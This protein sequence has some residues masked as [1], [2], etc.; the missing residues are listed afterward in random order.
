[1]SVKQPSQMSAKELLAYYQA[2]LD[3]EARQAKANG[4]LVCWSASVAPPELCVAMDIAMVYPETHA[5]GIGARKGALD[6]LE[7]ADRLG[8][9]VDCCSYG[10]VN[11]GYMELLK[12]EAMTGKTPE[13]L[14]NSPAARVPLPDLVITCNNICNTLLKWYENLAAELDIPC[15][16]IDVPFNHTMPVSEESKAYIADQFRNAISQLEV[17]CGRPFDYEKFHAVRQ[18]TQRSIAQWNRIATMSQYKP[19]PLNGF[20]LF[21]YMALV[22]C[23]RS[24]DYAEITFRKFADELEEKY[25]KGESAFKGAEKNRVAWEGIAVWP[26]LGHTFKTLKNQGSIMTGSAYPNIWDLT[27]DAEDETLHSMAEAYT[28]TYINT[29]LDNKV[30]VL[31]GIMDRGKCDGV[32]YHLN[33][34]CKLMS[35]LNVET[36]ELIQQ[37]NGLPYVSFDG[38][39]TDPRN[40]APAQ[41]DTRVE[42]LGEMMDQAAQTAGE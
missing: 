39:Q 27:Y 35:F 8:Y 26:Y 40:F 14:A 2:K 37:A 22:V 20:D 24:R 31:R 41:Y 29:C 10:R 30:K 18:Q 34:S 17:I 15:I 4:K 13:V 7:V 32:V 16:I 12:E 38:D 42:A 28:R 6:M 1:M 5:A 25:K 21:N 11:I 9:N 19:S 36:A 3:E 33:R 23:A